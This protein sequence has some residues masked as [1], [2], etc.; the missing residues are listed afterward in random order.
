MHSD[1]ATRISQPASLSR[2]KKWLF[3]LLVWVALLGLGETVARIYIP[4]RGHALGEVRDR[5]AA[6]AELRLKWRWDQQANDYPYLPYIP[7]TKPPDIEMRGLRLT[8]KDDVKPADVFRVFCLGGST[9]YLGY[10]KKLEAEL[11]SDF[12]N[13]GLRLEVVNAAD[14][15]W[16][17]AES[18][19]NFSLR[20]L[21]YEP[22]AII[23]Y[24]AANDCW[25]AFGQTYRP[26]YAHWRKRLV[27]NQPVVWDHLP[28][29]LDASAAYVQLRAWSEAGSM[30]HRWA[31]S[32]MHYVPDFEQDPYHGLESYRRNVINLIAVA[33]AHGVAVL[34]STQVCNSEVPEKRHVAA[35]REI[36][37][38]TRSLADEDNGVFLVDPTTAIQGNYELMYDICHF[39]PEKDG[40]ARLVLTLA[41]AVRAHMDDWIKRRNLV[42]GQTGRLAGRLTAS[43]TL[44]QE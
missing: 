11:A 6:R 7:K 17:T 26:D 27:H 20:C 1:P 22:D 2:R 29:F 43:A 8:S 33:R 40:E 42:T 4:W 32:M 23:V 35:V 10:P 38:I 18:F 16:T 24:H 39:R 5:Y 25:P 21:P 44:P 14:I 13:R 15:S 37:D 31:T 19:I 12:A 41:D 36:N 30:I 28:Q 34:L 3:V 9:T